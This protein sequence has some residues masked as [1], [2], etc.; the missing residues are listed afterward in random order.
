M[1][2]DLSQHAKDHSLQAADDFSGFSD[3]Y[4]IDGEI[5][6][7]WSKLAD[8]FIEILEMADKNNMSLKASKTVF[9]SESAMFFGHILDK[10]GSRSADH[11]LTPIEK[12]WHQRT[13]QSYDEYLGYASSIRT[14][15]QITNVLLSHYSS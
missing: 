7:D 6:P 13:N 1:E 10:D 2:N 9:G 15:Y 5:L 3:D 4:E 8:D 11:N 12:W 14:P